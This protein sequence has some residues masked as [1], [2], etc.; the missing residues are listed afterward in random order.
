MSEQEPVTEDLAR[1]II[2]ENVEH[3]DAS[4][5]IYDISHPNLTHL[6]ERRLLREDMAA[7]EGL[8]AG[9]EEVRAVDVG[10]GTGRLALEFARR[11]W[12]VTAVDN[13]RE[14]L[15]LAHDKHQRLPEAERIRQT[16]EP[17]PLCSPMEKLTSN[18]GSDLSIRENG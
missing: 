7:L 6:Y 18:A 8:L 12:D 15:R 3:H 17:T 13:S 11:G 16:P 10:A 5:P 2:R 9:K 1:R 4:A 14:M